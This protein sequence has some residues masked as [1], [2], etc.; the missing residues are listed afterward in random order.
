MAGALAYAAGDKW[1]ATPPAVVPSYAQSKKPTLWKV[2]ENTTKAKPQPQVDARMAMRP[3]RQTVPAGSFG[4]CTH[5]A[6]VTGLGNDEGGADG[7]APRSP[8]GVRR[9]PVPAKGAHALC[10]GCSIAC[11]PQPCRSCCGAVLTPTVLCLAAEGRCRE[12]HRH[13]LRRDDRPA[14]CGAPPKPTQPSETAHACRGAGGQAGVRTDW[15]D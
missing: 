4:A 3:C 13:G 8:E 2:V 6:L 5:T 12:D 10:C 15:A 14:P 9:E 7:E 1:A 11:S